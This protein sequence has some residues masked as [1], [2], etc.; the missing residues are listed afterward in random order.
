MPEKE[1]DRRRIL[2][3]VEGL[4]YF[5]GVIDFENLYKEVA[6]RR[7]AALSRQ[8]FKSI[9]DQE[10]EKQDSSREIFFEDGLY[11]HGEA[12]YPR[13][14]LEEQEKRT[15]IGYRPVTEK[16]VHLVVNRQYTLLWSPATKKLNEQLQKKFGWSEKE[17]VRRISFAQFLLKNGAPQM[18]LVELFLEDLDFG[19]FDALQP[20]ANLISDLANHTP[21]WIL[22]GWS[23]REIFERFEKPALRPLP[24]VL[25]APEEEQLRIDDTIKVGRNE[26]CPCG[27]DKKYKKCCGAPAGE[28]EAVIPPVQENADEA[29]NPSM[30]DWRALYEAAASYKEARSWEWMYNDDLFGVMDPA[31]SEIAYCCIMGELGEHYGLGAYRGPE[32]LK[33]A[34]DILESPIESP[35]FFFA[36]KCLMAS[37]ENREILDREDRAVIKELGLKFRGRKQWPLFRFHEPGFHPWFIDDGEC[38]FLTHILQQAQDVSR[39]CRDSKAILKHDHSGTF[40]VRVPS[41]EKG[42]IHWSDQYL[43]AAPF[44]TKHPIFKI[45]DELNLRRL[46]SSAKRSGDTW[47]ADTFFIP[48]PVQEE[49][50]E[51]PYYPKA[52]LLFDSNRGLI[53]AHE[54]M[55]DYSKEGQHCL[56]RIV[57][58]I[59][60]T[61]IPSRILV[62]R[63]ETFHLLKEICHRLKITLKKVEELSSIPQ[64]REELYNRVW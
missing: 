16:E 54:L 29:S 43:E 60:R 35:D 51:R 34:L 12:D 9:L 4:L 2:N 15:G 17:A 21:Q 18:Q 47:E 62:G 61:A 64:I 31:T 44:V 46:L 32:G 49:K 5:Y 48:M 7:G 13:W 28:T 41:I 57:E 36:Q 42:T 37:F 40:L 22:K 39:R 19:S 38:R 53:L 30:E 55:Q 24:A 1:P 52:F 45:T 33:S 8:Q 11:C 14:L 27:S 59:S 58:L 3:W 50:G 25:F 20:I 6:K 63:E 26:P 23:S 10:L 56:D